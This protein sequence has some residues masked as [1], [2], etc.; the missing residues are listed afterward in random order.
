MSDLPMIRDINKTVTHNIVSHLTLAG[1][2]G[3]DATP[4]GFSENNSRTNQPIVTKLGIP[5]H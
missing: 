4:L 5:N 1:Q 3:V 2:E